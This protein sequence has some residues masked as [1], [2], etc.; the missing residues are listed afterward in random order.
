[1]F[2]DHDVTI[3]IFVHLNACGSTVLGTKCNDRLWHGILF[4]K[5]YQTQRLNCM[6]SHVK[7]KAVKQQVSHSQFTIGPRQHLVEWD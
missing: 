5:W 3:F 1:M 2:N 6:D 4:T 7:R